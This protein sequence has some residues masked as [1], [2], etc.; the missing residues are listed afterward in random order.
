MIYLCAGC[1]HRIEGLMC[2]LPKIGAKDEKTDI[3][4]LYIPIVSIY[5]KYDKD[6]GTVKTGINLSGSTGLDDSRFSQVLRWHC[7]RCR[8]VSQLWFQPMR[9][10]G[11]ET[12]SSYTPPFQKEGSI[13][14]VLIGGMSSHSV[15]YNDVKIAIAPFVQF[16][17]P[18]T[19]MKELEW[20]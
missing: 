6:S 19:G 18:L 13:V 20:D 15:S 1:L 14:V 12:D 16:D 10:N 5:G 11:N 7:P 8:M 17:R 9:F 2:V 4:E 3:E